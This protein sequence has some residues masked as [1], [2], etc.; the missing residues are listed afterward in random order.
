MTLDRHVISWPTS[1]V[2]PSFI[3]TANGSRLSVTHTG[4]ITPSSDSSGNL[5]LPMVLCIPNLAMRLISISQITNLNYYVSFGPTSCVVQDHTGRKIGAGRKEHGLYV[6]EYLHLP[7]FAF[8]AISLSATSE[9]WHHSLGHPSEARLRHLFKTGAL[10]KFSFSSLNKCEHCPL[11]KQI[12][13]SFSSSDNVSSAC[14]DLVHSDVWGPSPILS[15]SGYSYYICFVDDFSRYTWVY[16][17][18]YRF[19]VFQIYT[20]FT[21]MIHTQYQKRIKIFRSDGTKVY[22]SLSMKNLLKSHGTIHQQS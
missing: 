18:R 4:N 14:F 21:N 15:I 19:E 20:D 11:A 12:A 9:L 5:T 1:P 10:G 16:L 6:L 13:T 8:P 22:L 17:L 3:Y 2:R 7:L